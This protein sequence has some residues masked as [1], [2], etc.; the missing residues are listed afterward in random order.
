MNIYSIIENGIKTKLTE[1]TC[2]KDL[3]VMIDPNLDFQ[4]HMTG[5]VK[6]ARRISTM[7]T[8]HISFKNKKYHVTL[9]HGTSPANYRVWKHSVEY[10]GVPSYP[11]T[12]SE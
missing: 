8:R 2:E 3:G 5:A 10:F 7:L 9:V 4:E 6:K 12:F 1:T 11:K